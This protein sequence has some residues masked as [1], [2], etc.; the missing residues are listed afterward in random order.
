M[1]NPPMSRE[2]SSLDLP[3]RDYLDFAT[4]LG[5]IRIAVVRPGGDHAA[6]GLAGAWFIHEQKYVPPLTRHWLPAPDHSLLN[7]ARDELL[8][9]FDGR[10]SVLQVPLAPVG[11]P[12]QQIVWRGLLDIGFAETVSYSAFTAAIG[13]P[14]AAVRA[15][16]GAISRNPLSVWIP[17]HRVL[18]RNGSLTGYAGGLARKKFLLELEQTGRASRLPFTL[19]G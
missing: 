11:T 18:G 19:I 4:P 10:R 1:T 8:D 13:Q 12:F 15:V 2:R 16:A 7:E 6:V 3:I 5:D 17:C 14:A 9:W